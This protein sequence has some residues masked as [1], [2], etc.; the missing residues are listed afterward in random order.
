MFEP[1]TRHKQVGEGK[2]RATSQLLEW[3]YGAYEGLMTSE[4]RKSREE[5]SLDGKGWDHFKDGCE[6]GEYVFSQIDI[7]RR[8]T[9]T[10]IAGRLSISQSELMR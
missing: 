3:D 9:L 1:A 10:Q 2:V 4:I 6:D 5:R 7:E 8:W